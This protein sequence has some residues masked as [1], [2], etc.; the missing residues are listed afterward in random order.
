MDKKLTIRQHLSII[1]RGLK[2]F[3]KFP[4]P[5]LLSMTLSNLFRSAIPFINIWF[6]ARIINELVGER[7]QNRLIFLVVL[8]ISLNLTTNLI[9][10]ALQRWR[11]VCSS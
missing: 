5:V 8:T 7:D 10:G 11:V 3:A 2:I 6:S 1:F 9:G 4:R